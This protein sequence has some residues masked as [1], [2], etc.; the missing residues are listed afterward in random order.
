MNFETAVVALDLSPASEAML[1]CMTDL[2]RWG[3]R[4][5]ILVHVVEVGYI[6]GARYGREADCVGW[7]ER[8][9]QRLREAELESEVLVCDS[10]VPADEILRAAGKFRADL[11][12]IGSRGH[13]TVRDLFVG[14]V[15]RD[16]MQK[17]QLPLL[18]ERVE[19]TAEAQGAL[20]RAV[21]T[22]TLRRVLLASDFSK[23]SMG[24]EEAAVSLAPQ[25]Q[26]VDCLHVMTP[27]ARE[28]TPALPTMA[29][30]ALEAILARIRSRGGD[31]VARLADGDPA[32]TIA[33]IADEE[34]SS[35]ILLGKHGQ[36]RLASLLLGSTAA[37]V[38]E[39]ARCPVL[40]VPASE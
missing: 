21:C 30:A 38:G 28:A 19:P 29:Q 17:S 12:V 8:H 33:R 16:V 18:L 25:S 11:V 26:R 37:R 5:V 2:R 39:I 34:G 24:A 1:E 23:A 15:A 10:G 35:L 3:I 7:L 31:G 40:M 32:D 20:C 22:D 4:K 36:G 14:S 6:R 27:A 9:G 13:S